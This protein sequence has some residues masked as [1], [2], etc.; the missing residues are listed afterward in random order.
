MKQISRLLFIAVISA[1]VCVAQS[2]NGNSTAAAPSEKAQVSGP[3]AQSQGGIPAGSV[4]AA[5]LS[6]SIDAKKAK[7]GDKVEAKVVMD[8]LS[9]G[10]VV[11]PRNS[12][13]L[14]HVVEAKAHSKD[15]AGSTLSIA[16]DRIAL[17]GGG[18]LPFQSRIQAI[19]R[20]LQ[21]AA[22]PDSSAMGD[23][24]VSASSQSSVSVGMGGA[25]PRTS[26]GA[27]PGS[28][29][30][31]SPSSAD[32][33]IAPEKGPA[34]LGPNSEGVVGIKGLELKSDAQSSVI[35]SDKDN[36]KLE[37]GTQIILRTQ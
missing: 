26:G 23:P 10:K 12:K 29:P 32:P 9:Q 22:M 2:P 16:F 28:Y 15:S 8:L 1:G 21:M 18:E 17:K 20:P 24:S 14:G 30:G 4:I 37:S 6:K 34:P 31:A 5:E 35:S 13:V 11:I 7:T 3:R 27:A 25:A 19:G 36:V 33:T